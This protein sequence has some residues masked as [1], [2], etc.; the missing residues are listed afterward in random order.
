MAANGPVGGRMYY[1]LLDFVRIFAFGLICYNHL[2]AVEVKF[3]A[4]SFLNPR[5][6]NGLSGVD[7]FFVLS[8]FMMGRLFLSAPDA[9]RK[10]AQIYLVERFSRIYPLYWLV[11]TAL[12]I[13]YLLR[14]DLVYSSRSAVEPD[15]LKTYLLWPDRALPLHVIAWTLTHLM[16]FYIVTAVMF[17]IPRRLYAVF[18]AVWAVATIVAHQFWANSDIPELALIGNV[19]TVQY[20]VGLSLGLVPALSWDKSKYLAAL[21]L[22]W[23]VGSMVFGYVADENLRTF[24]GYERFF[25]ACPPAAIL[26]Y[27]IASYKRPMK[28]SKA[29]FSLPNVAKAGYAFYLSHVLSF[30][31]LAMVFSRFDLP[32]IW[33]N[34]VFLLMT[35]VLSFIASMLVERFIEAPLG[36]VM[37]RV[38]LRRKTA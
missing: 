36:R 16:Y 7:F 19:F 1:P 12:L 9:H 15:L 27:A 31:V 35:V 21:G 33:D 34:V 17:L 13:A 6:I 3:F 30:T 29:F 4:D 20:I 24:S 38:P 8:G 37:R 25:F 22:T 11:T 10:S 26:I 18:L 28:R 14:P 32:G 5:V 23:L 2:T